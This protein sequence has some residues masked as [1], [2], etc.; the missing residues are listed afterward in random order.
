MCFDKKLILFFAINLCL[1]SSSSAEESKLKATL[2]LR[3]HSHKIAEADLCLDQAKEILA[4]AQEAF[5][6]NNWEIVEG[7]LEEA[8]NEIKKFCLLFPTTAAERK[9]RTSLALYHER[10]YAQ[11]AAVL[12]EMS[13]ELRWVNFY[14]EPGDLRGQINLIQKYLIK[15]KSSEFEKAVTTMIQQV[16]IPA[17]DE[18]IA[19]IEAEILI[20]LA[21]W[22]IQDQEK[23]LQHL[24]SAQNALNLFS[25]KVDLAQARHYLARSGHLAEQKLKR[26]E[27]RRI[28]KES[29]NRVAKLAAENP[30]DLTVQDLLH[31]TQKI[32][33]EWG[34]KDSSSENDLAGLLKKFDALLLANHK[35]ISQ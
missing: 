22:K 23:T 12:E 19:F 21:S 11:A 16:S 13:E 32:R 8:Q 29:V 33:Q 17:I 27:A 14:K 4:A 20:S 7:Y 3:T 25:P 5:D 2:A 24:S 1:I 18:G 34:K 6:N 15:Q 31:S 26:Y 35:S 30:D 9:L 28:L 10:K